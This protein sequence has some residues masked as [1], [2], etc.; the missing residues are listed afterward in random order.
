M[1]EAIEKLLRAAAPSARELFE[2][3]KNKVLA[4]CN[5]NRLKRLI[6]FGSRVREDRTPG[7]DLDLVTQF[8]PGTSLLD[9]LRIQDEL[10]AAIGCR[11]DLG[12]MPGPGSR[13]RRHIEAEGVGLVGAKA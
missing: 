4:V 7:S 9:V 12:S 1:D 3:N 8:P 2:R 6:A 13:L 5:R 10:S 11:V